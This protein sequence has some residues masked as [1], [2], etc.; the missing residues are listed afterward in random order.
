MLK[1]HTQTISPTGRCLHR[2]VQRVKKAQKTRCHCEPVPQH[3]C[4]NPHSLKR[5]ESSKFRR[6]RIATSAYGLLAMTASVQMHTDFPPK[7]FD[8][9]TFPKFCYNNPGSSEPGCC[10][11]VGG[12]AS[13]LF[14][15]RGYA[16]TFSPPVLFREGGGQNDFYGTV[17]VL[18]GTYWSCRSDYRDRKQEEVTA[19][20]QPSGYFF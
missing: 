1:M 6:K 16:H 13:L 18:F 15:N 19:Q 20:L 8:I 10:H 11:P 5:S 3:W 9:D 12:S 2:P 17:S 14:L 4:G 7:A